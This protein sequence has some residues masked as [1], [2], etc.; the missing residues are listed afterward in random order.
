MSVR[1]AIEMES[2]G[3]VEGERWPNSS[4]MRLGDIARRCALNQIGSSQLVGVG[5]AIIKNHQFHSKTKTIGSIPGQKCVCVCVCVCVYLCTCMCVFVYMYV[6]ICVHICVCVHVYVCMHVYVCVH[7]CVHVYVCMCMCMCMCVCMCVCMCMCVCVL[8]VM[9]C[10]SLILESISSRFRTL[11]H[12][13]Q[14]EYVL[15]KPY[16]SVNIGDTRQLPRNDSIAH[17]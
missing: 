12:L 6:C 5:L 13:L 10:S 7:V 2:V 8:G 1:P 16:A 3:W 9:V 11:G 17:S 15:S 4:D 14:W